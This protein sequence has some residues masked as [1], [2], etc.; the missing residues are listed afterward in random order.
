MLSF[1]NAALKA[2]VKHDSLLVAAQ[3]LGLLPIIASFLQVMSFNHEKKPLILLI[4]ASQSEL[5]SLQQELTE[6]SSNQIFINQFTDAITIDKRRH[7]YSQG[8]IIS[9]TK[10]IIISDLLLEAIN[11]TQITGM[12]ML[13]AERLTEFSHERFILQ[14]YR[15]SNNWGFLKLLTDKPEK[16]T[17]LQPLR[18]KLRWSLLENT[19]LLPRFHVQVKSSLKSQ[20]VTEIK[21]KMT[22]LMAKLQSSLLKSITDLLSELR[23]HVPNMENDHWIVDNAENENFIGGIRAQLSGEWHRLKPTP[24]II[25]SDLD[26]V[27]SLLKNLFIEDSVI[28]NQR[29]IDYFT[30]SKDKSAWIM[31]DAFSTTLTCSQQRVRKRQT[32]GNYIDILEE[33]PKWEELCIILQEI[34]DEKIENAENN[35]GP[36]VIACEDQ[37]TVLQLQQ[38]LKLVKPIFNESESESESERT[39]HY[40]FTRYM[41]KSW[42][43]VKSFKE[44]N[45]RTREI[46]K[47]IVQVE[48]EKDEIIVSGTY[49]GRKQSLA[50]ER[51]GRRRMRGGAA[52]QAFDR[53][54]DKSDITEIDFDYMPNFDPE[55]ELIEDD[56]LIY[57]SQSLFSNY[58]LIARSKEIIIAPFHSILLEELMPSHIILYQPNLKFLRNIELQQSLQST[59]CYLL[60]Y[61]NSSEERIFYNSIEKEKNA[62]TKLIREKGNMGKFFTTLEEQLQYYAPTA[63]P[64]STTATISNKQ[65]R[66]AG[67]SSFTKV[68][69]KKIIVDSREL[70][71]TLPFLL[72][73][74]G[75]EVI[76]ATLEVGDYI[77]SNDICIERKTLPDLRESLNKGRLFEQCAR[78]FE[79]YS[80]PCLLI[81]FDGNN[82]FSFEQVKERFLHANSNNLAPM[83]DTEGQKL[84]QGLIALVKA[85]PD[86][87]IIWAP[88]VTDAAKACSDL[89]GEVDLEKAV[90]VGGTNGD[91]MWEEVCGLQAGVGDWKGSLKELSMLNKEQ[92][93]ILLGKDRGD[94]AWQFFNKPLI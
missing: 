48:P 81:E 16:L 41:H 82:S 51:T 85:Y 78:M 79:F 61:D 71:S 28:F 19:I 77:L 49:L 60:T 23:R 50:P 59:P 44:I 53:L 39:I 11:P 84:Q 93:I 87:R 46:T 5:E 3:G 12:I 63:T 94:K 55:D 22:P 83:L 64:F 33:L 89:M 21:V 25:L 58:S 91:G 38:M 52:I 76:P 30:N 88:S 26:V 1:Q 90:G 36:V 32:N 13:H 72:H 42:S 27:V 6:L 75:L 7:I 20:Q 67:G 47:K 8:G 40:D 43:L 56:L 54:H 70:R 80:K 57:E 92:L 15:R 31:A 14:L 66:N 74:H 45:E 62:F 24:K 34:Q 10:R 73:L 37:R 4:N 65:S 68:K 69:H 2:L 18:D 17:G 29:I 35:D 9:V 86:L